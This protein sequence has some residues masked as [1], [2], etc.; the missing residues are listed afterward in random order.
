MNVKFDLFE[1]FQIVATCAFSANPWLS[2][3]GA[4]GAIV[5]GVAAVTVILICKKI[6]SSFS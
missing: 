3:G 6:T 4:V 2:P 1:V 5:G